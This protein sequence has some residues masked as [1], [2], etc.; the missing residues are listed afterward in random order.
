MDW[1]RIRFGEMIAGAAAGALFIFMF[2]PWYGASAQVRGGKISGGNTNAWQAFSFIDILLF[3]VVAV[4]IGLVLARAADAIP[5][6]L[7]APAGL[8]VA[9]AGGVAVL[10]ILFRLVITPGEDVVGLGLQVEVGRKIGVFLGLIAAGAIA[11]GG[12]TAMNER[13]D[14]T[15]KS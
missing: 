15:V 1:S 6:T 2:F 9:V 14:E 3:L 12:Y 13:A 5:A 11:F 8:I 10:L 4:T 7:P